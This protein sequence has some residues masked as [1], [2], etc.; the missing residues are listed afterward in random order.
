PEESARPLVL[1]GTADGPGRPLGRLD[2]SDGRL[3]PRL[4]VRRRLLHRP[5]RAVP[6][7]VGRA[8]T[9]LVPARAGSAADRDGCAAQT[10]AAAKPG[11]LG[12]LPDGDRAARHQH[13][14]LLLAELSPVSRPD[15]CARADDHAALECDGA[16]AAQNLLRHHRR[17]LSAACRRVAL[18]L[19]HLY[20]LSPDSRGAGGA[21]LRACHDRPD[22]P[23]RTR[24]RH[25]SLLR[26]GD[27][28]VLDRA[29]A[30][31][32]GLAGRAA[33]PT[34][35]RARRAA[36]LPRRRDAGLARRG[37][38]DSVAARGG[39]APAPQLLDDAAVLLPD[40]GADALRGRVG[41]A[42]PGLDLYPDAGAGDVRDAQLHAALRRGR[43]RER[44]RD[45]PLSDGTRHACDGQRLLAARRG[46][47]APAYVHLGHRSRRCRGLSGLV[48]LLALAQL[49]LRRDSPGRLRR[50]AGSAVVAGSRA[51]VRQHADEPAS[52]PSGDGRAGRVSGVRL[53]ATEGA[54]PLVAVRAYRPRH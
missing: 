22:E 39:R 34:G 45:G 24:H 9:P 27:L 52:G 31:A 33:S 49:P 3:G 2:E 6:Q 40:P 17:D 13:G 23:S 11:L 1:R 54:V 12:G 18:A 46:P 16:A 25:G 26:A 20:R 43:L 29:P 5:V 19:V 41:P 32:G 47:N 38:P 21:R 50:A 42:L 10:L 15:R 7:A 35:G 28:A 14:P 53:P 48:R 44:H 4:R 37:G 30:L 36:L 8:R 51:G